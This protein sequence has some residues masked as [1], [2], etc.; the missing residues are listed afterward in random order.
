M[1]LL[2]KRREKKEAERE[3]RERFSSFVGMKVLD[4]LRPRERYVFHSDYFDVDDGVATILTYTHNDAAQD[5][6]PPFWGINRIPAGLPKSVVTVNLESISRMS[7]S[8]INAHQSRAEAIAET[9]Q[10]EQNRNGS[11][12]TR[13]K[14]ESRSRDIAII[15]RE[16]TSGESYLNVQ[17]RVLVKA[18]DL[19]T[20]DIAVEKLERLYSDR[21]GTIG[22]MAYAGDQRRELSQLFARNELRRGKGM[23]ATSSE[24]AGSYSLVTHGLE[25]VGGE[26]VGAMTGDVNNASVLF[27]VDAY[28]HHVVI[29]SEGINLARGRARV[30]DM[31]GSKIGQACLMN[32][33][34]VVHILLA[35][36][37]MSR[38]GPEFK[39]FTTIMDMNSGDLN[40]FE[41][42]GKVEDELAIF[43][44]QMQKLILM[45][46]QAYATT[47]A[48]RAIIRGTLEEIATKFYVEQGMWREN[49]GE[50]REDLRVVGIP[51][52]DVPRLQTFV[53]YLD[54]EHKA[55]INSEA[56]DDERIHA[57]SVLRQT[58]RNLLTNNGDLFN[59]IT[60]PKIDSIHNSRRTIYDFSS[61]MDRGK[62]IAMAQLVNVIDLAVSQCSEHDVVIVH[63]A[64]N[65]DEG[66]QEYVE[67]QFSKLWARGGRVALT[68][69]N[70][71]AMI[72]AVGFNNFDTADYTIVS[73]MSNNL[74]DRYQKAL[75][76]RIPPDLAN[77]ITD[78]SSNVMYIRR[79]FD[80]VV[81]QL[82]LQLDPIEVRRRRSRR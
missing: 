29:A 23:Y 61:L 28:R 78:K 34:K 73:N 54:M 21:F 7:E 60:S 52:E 57:V 68:Y 13:G 1:G 3:D 16:L 45:A 80:N 66:V 74:V 37:D 48:D 26:F 31:W 79:G 76:Q 65:I 38:L 62:G 10:N 24:L 46:E 49:A 35:P 64:E 12:S 20:L 43:S 72:D 4:R 19:E 15:G 71:A 8:W 9:D 53:S 2:A 32:G 67:T 22:V 18:P 56:R 11:I 63:G 17:T 82:D 25:D 33:G 70:L 6:F 50:R 27:D 14:A 47:D 81:F 39:S 30:S 75:G 69:G 44:S 58:F 41:M 36:C 42:F 77:L 5:N 59:V 55:L 40:P 51:H